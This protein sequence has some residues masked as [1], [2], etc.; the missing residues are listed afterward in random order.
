[1]SCDECPLGEAPEF[2]FV[3][4]ALDPSV[5]CE[6]YPLFCPG[7][8]IE[9]ETFQVACTC[10]PDTNLYDC[11]ENSQ[12]LLQ[13]PGTQPCPETR[14][15]VGDSCGPFFG[16]GLF[17]YVSETCPYGQLCCP[18]G[19]CIDD[20]ICA[21]GEDATVVCEDRSPPFFFFCPAICPATQP[22]DFEACSIDSRFECE[23]GIGECY[24]PLA[25]S[26]PTTICDCFFG[27][28]SCFEVCAVCPDSAPSPNE[29]CVTNPSV[30]CNYN[31]L[32]CPGWEEL[33]LFA[34]SCQCDAITGQ[35]ECSNGEDVCPP[36]PTCPETQPMS[37]ETCGDDHW[38]ISG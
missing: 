37:G 32:Y 29:P 6:Y 2:L 14:P 3:A 13:C 10:D 22:T 4:C 21:C 24:N 27:L 8:D 16:L 1:L 12:D 7:Q 36:A 31:Q 17:N 30:Q 5:R 23:Y 28:W 35:F 20:V 38:C 25:A 15:T 19:E 9:E 26:S 18:D 11:N 34:N 33:E